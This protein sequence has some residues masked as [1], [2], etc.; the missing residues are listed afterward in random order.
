MLTRRRSIKLG[1]ERIH[2]RPLTLEHALE[3]A[4]LLAPHLARIEAYLPQIKTALGVTD[5]TRPQ[6][7]AA[8]FTSL[9]DELASTP[10][11][12]TKA[13]ALLVDRDPLWV[14]QNATARELVDALPVLDEIND[15]AGLYE[16]A[17]EL[18][19]MTNG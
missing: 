13:L 9:R 14:A 16:S 4:L 17:R 6:V 18:G 2:P 11:D 10:G 1:G 7:L 19:L 3:L 5:G 8:L 15:L 12:M